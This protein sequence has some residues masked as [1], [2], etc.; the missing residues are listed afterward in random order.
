MK[1]DFFYLQIPINRRHN[2]PFRAT[3][4]RS[5]IVQKEEWGREDHGP[6][7]LPGEKNGSGRIG[8]LSKL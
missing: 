5:R 7:S 2:I 8:M 6:E 1:R 3:W 4:R